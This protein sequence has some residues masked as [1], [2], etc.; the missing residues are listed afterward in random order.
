MTAAKPLERSQRGSNINPAYT[1]VQMEVNMAG[2]HVMRGVSWNKTRTNAYQWKNQ[3]PAL[4]VTKRKVTLSPADPILTVSL[5]IGLT[6][7][8]VLLP[9][10]LTTAN[11]CCQL[12]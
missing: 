7:F 2:K 11:L 4:S 5:Q 6:K 8:G 3:G 9:A 12:H 10:T 1:L